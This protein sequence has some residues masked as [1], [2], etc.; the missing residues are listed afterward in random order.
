MQ[1]HQS[2]SYVEQKWEGQTFRL[3]QE[4]CGSWSETLRSDSFNGQELL[5]QLKLKSCGLSKQL[6]TRQEYLRPLLVERFHQALLEVLSDLSL[7]DS[8]QG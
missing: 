2:P 6:K 7:L 5:L 1:P 4:L 8:T 3:S